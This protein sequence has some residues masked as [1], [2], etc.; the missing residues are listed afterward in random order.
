[1]EALGPHD[2]NSQASFVKV[3]RD[4]SERKEAEET[5]L[6]QERT[7]R[8]ANES[9]TRA[10]EDLKNFAFAAG[11]DLREPL[12]MV[13]AYSQLLVKAVRDGRQDT[14]EDSSASLPRGRAG[15]SG[16]SETC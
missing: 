5:L 15:W 4:N 9:L 7:L 1:M 10:N 16:C 14:I 2:L 3:L 6:G 13:T 12:R 8:A 11:H